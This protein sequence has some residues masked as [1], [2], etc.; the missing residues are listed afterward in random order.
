MKKNLKKFILYH[1]ID[2]KNGN[3]KRFT[4]YW[5]NIEVDDGTRFYVMAWFC[6]IL[7]CLYSSYSFRLLFFQ[8][9]EMFAKVKLELQAVVQTNMGTILEG[10]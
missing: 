3:I 10:L 2:A 8:E 5:L 6:Y 9:I 4:G 7:L 1:N